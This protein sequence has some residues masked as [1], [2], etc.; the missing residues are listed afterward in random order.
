[1][2]KNIVFVAPFPTDPT[3]RFL[4]AM[5]SLD[6]IKLLG[7]VHTPPSGRDAELFDDIARV[8]QPLNVADL[9]KGVEELQSRHGQPERIVG[10]LEAMMV[11]LAELREHF[12]VPGTPRKTAEL[13]RDKAKMKDAL[14]AAGLP[15]ARH[16]LVT[17]EADARAFIEE[18]GF[19]IVVKPP[20]GMGARSTFRVSSMVAFLSALKE[21]NVSADAPLLAE[22]MLRGKEH[23]FETITLGGVPRVQSFAQYFPGPLEVLENPWIQWAC[24]LPREIDTPLYA[25]VHDLGVATIRTLGLDDGMTHMEWYERADGSVAIGEI[26]QR[27][28]GPQLCQMTGLVNDVNIY[29]AW[30]RAVVDGV[31]DAPWTRK[32]AAGTAF[33]RG[34][35]QGRVAAIRGIRETHAAIAPYLVEAK[36]PDI[37]APKG[38]S[39][40]GDGYVMVRAETTE[41]VHELIKTVLSTI[42][43]HYVA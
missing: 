6:D 38:D 36:L 10:I 23:S 8:T 20:A 18:V 9:I 15:V 3:L 42:K 17:I 24:V 16:K 37:G 2:P 25:R 5:R 1:M 35:G 28:P 21:M 40:E 7:V 34:V 30:A 4:R 29:R 39:Y 11:Q 33:I 22:E 13:F 26:A 31:L 19:P 14:R 12:G 43:I 27:P 41:K 32:Y